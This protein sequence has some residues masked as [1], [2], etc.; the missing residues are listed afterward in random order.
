VE[1][2]A[3]IVGAVSEEVAFG[4]IVANGGDGVIGAP[5]VGKGGD[6]GGAGGV[7][8]ADR[9]VTGGGGELVDGPVMIYGVEC[10]AVG[11]FTDWEAVGVRR[12]IRRFF[13][14]LIC[15]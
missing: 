7:P 2:D 3:T 1:A 9:G 4:G 5:E 8:E 14:N 10:V 12:S 15:C 6:R 11:V 13:F